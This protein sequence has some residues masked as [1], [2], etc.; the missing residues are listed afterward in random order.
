MAAPQP[1]LI[2]QPAPAANIAE[3]RSRVEAALAKNDLPAA[4]IALREWTTQR[5][6]DPAALILQSKLYL[7]LDAPAA[8]IAS[9]RRGLAPTASPAATPEQRQTL[10]ALKAQ[11]H[12]AVEEPAAAWNAYSELLETPSAQPTA[13]E[14]IARRARWDAFIQINRPAIYERLR[15]RATADASA[16]GAPVSAQLTLIRWVAASE[17]TARALSLLRQEIA[18][19]P[20]SPELQV[21]L[22]EL[23][24]PDACPPFGTHYRKNLIAFADTHRAD[25]DLLRAGGKAGF[26]GEALAGVEAQV[27]EYKAEDTKRTAP[28][29]LPKFVKEYLRDASTR[30]AAYHKKLS[31]HVEALQ[32]LSIRRFDLLDNP[33]ASAADWAKWEKDARPHYKPM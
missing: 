26:A 25:L 27:L 24:L 4:W 3:S 11:A 30:A 2:A 17:S 23:L 15:A 32:A 29:D 33:E 19:N 8:A 28:A 13:I 20:D 10:L 9:T 31:Q 14:K 12:T 22:A 18:K 6:D 7:R 5:P 1:R 16:P 21:A